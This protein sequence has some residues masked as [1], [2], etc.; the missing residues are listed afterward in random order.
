MEGDIKSRLLHK[1]G[2]GSKMFFKK[3]AVEERTEGYAPIRETVV[4]VN[5]CQNVAQILTNMNRTKMLSRLTSQVEETAIVADGLI[6]STKGINKSIEQQMVV[7]ESVVDEISNYSSLAEEVFASIESSKEISEQTLSTANEGTVAVDNVLGA[8]GEIERVVN[9]VRQSVN[10][11]FDKSQNIDDLL[12][13]IKDIAA[14]TN[15]LSLNAAIEAARAGEAGRGFAV[16]A[17]EVKNLASRSIESVSHINNILNEIKSSINNTSTLMLA[18]IDKVNDGKDISKETRHVFENIIQSAKETSNV[19]EEINKAISKQTDSLESVIGATHDMSQRF[20]QLM[21]TVE[22]TILSTELT[23]TSLNRLNELSTAI[24]ETGNE[25]TESHNELD[26]ELVLKGCEPYTITMIDPM[27]SSDSVDVRTL[28]NIYGTLI[29]ID[30]DGKVSPGLARYWHV[31][32]DQVTWEFQIRK[33][34]KFHNGETLTAEDVRFSYERLLSKALNAPCSW[35]LMDIEGS[36]DYHKG[37]AK[38]VSGIKVLN[39]YTI[40]IKLTSPYTGFLLNLGQAA[41]SV[42]SKRGFESG[43]QFIGCGPYRLEGYNEQCVTLKAFD[44]C[45]SGAPY[46]STVKMFSGEENHIKRVANRELDF[47][48]IEDGVAYQAAKDSNLSIKQLDMLGIYYMG[49]NLRS[50]HPVVQSKLARQALNYAINKE[51]IVNDVLGKYGSI[52]SSPMPPDM[53]LNSRLSPYAYN[54]QK[55]KELLRAA[56]ISNMTLNMYSRDDGS[57][58]LFKRTE[59]YVIED[60]QAVGFKV[61]VTSA[62]AAE[63]LRVRGFEKSDIYMSRWI[64][65]TGDQDNFLRPLFYP[66]NNDNF[67]DYNN[68]HVTQMLE[69]AKV[70]LNPTKR[71]EMYNQIAEAIHEDAPW[72]FLFHPKSGVAYHQ[73]LGGVNLNAISIVRYDQMFIK[74]L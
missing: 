57:N 74:R 31:H 67:S 21:K 37:I 59:R 65:D 8:M 36:E 72:A 39:P 9:E 64:A 30:S 56:G 62:P 25:Q 48:R 70:M 51:R 45:Y 71:A 14:S 40:S 27:A 46:I 29:N 15:L 44:E 60:L 19:A 2:L 16:V 3:R 38:T 41:A 26:N 35:V 47:A 28:Y 4:K 13:I 17:N 73:D 42:I 5:E 10:D 32:E 24:Q 55:A 12:N 33:G 58:G 1:E 34:V 7:I 53:L 50:N 63:F 66:H 6:D 43:G 20:G 69:D 22:V 18:A 23:S 54:P 52:A 68:P 49:F 61:N 11:L